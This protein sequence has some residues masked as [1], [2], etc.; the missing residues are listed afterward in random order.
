MIDVFQPTVVSVE[1][2]RQAGREFSE[3]VG[4]VNKGVNYVPLTLIEHSLGEMEI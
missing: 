2:L 4:D 1:E 3:A